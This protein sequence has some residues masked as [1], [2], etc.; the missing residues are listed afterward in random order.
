M[1]LRK[2]IDQIQ[3]R[4]ANLVLDKKFFSKFHHPNALTL[5]FAQSFDANFSNEHTEHPI[6]KA[7][8]RN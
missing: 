2:I 5:R 3:E 7:T 4:D 1:Q 6:L 8:D